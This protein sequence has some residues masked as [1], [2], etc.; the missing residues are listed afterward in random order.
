MKIERNQKYFTIARYATMTIIVSTLAI[1]AI[2]NFDELADRLSFIATVA[3]PITIGIFSAYILNP[4]MTYLENGMFGAL[5]RSEK[6]SKRNLARGLALTLTMLIVL[7][8]L[9]LLIILVIP[10]LAQNIIMLFDNM[11]DYLKHFRGFVNEKLPALK[12]YIGAPLDDLDK[13]LSNIWQN[14]SGE[15]MGFAGNLASGIMSVLDGMK[16]FFIGLTISV[17]LLAKKEM[18]I[19]Q[20]KKMLFAFVKP[21]RAQRVLSVCRE[22]SKKFLGSIIGKIIEAFL[23]GVLVFLVCRIVDM[24]YTP[25]LAVTMFLFN[26][27]PFVGP[28]IGAVPCSLL[29]LL[30]DSPQMTIW[31]IV[32]VLVL[33]TIDGNIIAPWILGDSTGL[34][35]VWVLIAIVIGGGFFKIPGMLLGVPVCAVL[36]ML[37]KD[38]VEGRLKKRRL[39]QNTM[40]YVGNVDYITEDYVYIEPE[41]P[42]NLE[43]APPPAVPKRY[44]LREVIRKKSVEHTKRV[45]N[46]RR[47]SKLTKKNEKK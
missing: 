41:E 28:F 31:F 22:A 13:L 42:E 7:A 40:Q 26:L 34:P 12:D 45:M 10:Q 11:D 6:R 9:V 33:Q 24:P 20:S 29:L 43:P 36:Y 46:P 23:V 27:I 25:L 47:S 30:S 8:V 38:Y 44:F 37:V 5:S 21:A 2:F 19:G 32:I 4:L 3:V 18:F 16:N 1:L 35:A 17:Y 14:H 15:V 39:P